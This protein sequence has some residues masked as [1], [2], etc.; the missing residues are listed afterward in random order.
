ML[1]RGSNNVRTIVVGSLVAV[2]VMFPFGTAADAGGGGCSDPVASKATTSPQIEGWCFTPAV[3]RVAPGAEITWTNRDP[4]RHNVQGAN[5]LW[6]S[7]PLD[8]GESVTVRFNREGTFPYL[9]QYHM[10]MIGAVV[11]GD[12][13][14]QPIGHNRGAIV[15]T[16]EKLFPP[17]PEGPLR[18][19]ASEAKRDA[20]AQPSPSL[21]PAAARDDGPSPFP[22]AWTVV[23]LG[24]LATLVGLMFLGSRRVD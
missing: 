5:Y 14:G 23:A 15:V 18:E 24:F 9:C 8:R 3:T 4:D 11:V 19:K 20:E 16:E 12:G 22:T 13:I 6:V 21:A 17:K 7:K 2:L 1:V 10:G